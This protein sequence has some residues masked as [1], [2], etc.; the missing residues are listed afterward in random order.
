V[1][2]IE[3][4]RDMA[5]APSVLVELLRVG[6]NCYGQGFD[7]QGLRELRWLGVDPTSRDL[8]RR[9]MW[10]RV[11]GKV[12]SFIRYSVTAAVLRARGTFVRWNI[13]SRRWIAII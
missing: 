3:Y 10:E 8:V 1:H 6:R 4:E 13:Q 5:G 2:S 9:N 12:G 11:P 7:R